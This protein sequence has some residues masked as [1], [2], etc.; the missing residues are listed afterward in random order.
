MRLGWGC[1]PAAA[2]ALVVQELRGDG[3]RFEVLDPGQAPVPLLARGLGAGELSGIAWVDSGRFLLVGDGGPPFAWDAWIDIDPAS[4]R[5]CAQSILARLPVAGLGTDVEGIAID[6]SR[7]TFLAADEATGRIRRFDL[8][9]RAACGSLRIPAIYEAPNLRPNFG[10]EALGCLRGE[11][12]TANEESLVSDGP[13]SSTESGGWVRLQRFDAEGFPAGQWAYRCDPISGMT[14]LVDV[15]RSGVVDLVPWDRGT[16]LVLEREFG[17]TAIPDFRSRLYA[18]DV[19]AATDVSGIRMLA[20][21]G[22]VPARKTLLWERGFPFCNFEAVTLGPPL[23][24]GR[25]S[26]VLVSDDGGGTGGQVQRLLSLVLHPVRA[27]PCDLDRSGVVDAADLAIM[28]VAWGPALDPLPSDVNGD[29]A[30]DGLDV[31]ALLSAWGGA[32]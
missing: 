28:L 12:W 13:P 20:A 5:I 14:D 9:S 32:G 10:F 11:A 27:A 23:G 19:S 8:E 31:S 24:G 3:T 16:V 17:G 22:F 1:A 4:G 29:C 21:G 26:L 15:E 2:L 25:R 6:R 30:V 7:G 18:V